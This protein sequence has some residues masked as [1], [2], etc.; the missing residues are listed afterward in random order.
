[1]AWR[2]MTYLERADLL[3]PFLCL[4]LARTRLKPIKLREIAARA[5]MHENSV[6]R[7]VYRTSWKGIPIETVDRIRG[8]CGICPANE[9]QQFNYLRRTFDWRKV[10]H[11]MAHDYKRH[12]S[13]KKKIN[14]LLHQIDL[15]A[16]FARQRALKVAARPDKCS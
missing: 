13:S 10:A 8:A 2:S 6:M 12:W 11:P 14:A 4:M 16:L 5:R 15:D 1:M 3:P 7:L 9:H